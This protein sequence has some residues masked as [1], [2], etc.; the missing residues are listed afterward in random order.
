MTLGFRLAG[1]K[2]TLTISTPE[3]MLK[4]LQQLE[5]KETTC[6]IIIGSDLYS[7]VADYVTAVQDRKPD[8]IFYKFP[9]DG[10]KWRV[11]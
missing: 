4:V 3:D 6:L 10:F 9:G 11:K 7:E 8:F 2:D 5:E 1:I